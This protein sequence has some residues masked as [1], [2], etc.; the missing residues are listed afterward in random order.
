MTAEGDGYRAAREGAA[1]IGLPERGVL[2]VTGPQRQKFLHNLLSNDVQGRAVGQGVLAA[3]MDA[4]GHLQSFLRVLV[5]SDTVWL[6]APAERL[7]A[8]EQ[9]FAHYRVAAPVRFQSTPAV[10]FALVGPAARDVLGRSGAEAP[11]A[12]PESHVGARLAGHE[13]RVAAASDLPSAGFVLHVAP[14]GADSVRAAL[15]A[16]GTAALGREALD[17]LRVEQGRPWYG[18]D[19]TDE[20]L[21]HET[22]LVREYHSPSKGCYVGQEVVARLEARGGNVNKLLRGL[23]LSAPVS[24]GASIR[25]EDREVGRVT[26][27]A[28]SPRLGPIAMGYVHRS[29]FEPGA[30]VQV[31]EAEATVEALPL[32]R[33]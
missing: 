17:A 30:R 9:T 29:R 11:S 15:L 21:L 3:L 7:P 20:N 26:T 19:V 10:V 23:R 25:A 32:D 22:G 28:V 16:E 13:V 12:A 8:L 2:A 31:G 14:E 1:L 27:A 5:A 33:T 18:V 4:R 6:E 24:A